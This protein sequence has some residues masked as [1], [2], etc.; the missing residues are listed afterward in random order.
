[1]A[2]NTVLDRIVVAKLVEV[3]KIKS[4]KPAGFGVRS[5]AAVPAFRGRDFLGALRSVPPGRRAVIAEL[6]RASP[7]AGI[8]RD[9]FEPAVLARAFESNGAAAL[10]A[11]T[12]VEFF[13]GSLAVLAEARA[14]T[15]LPVLRKDF[16]IDA[17]QVEEAVAAGADAVLLIARILDDELFQGLYDE[18]RSQ[19][20]AVLVEV[21][22]QRDLERSLAL[23]PAP[24]L[25]GI[26]NRNLSDFTVS[27][28]RTL[29]LL[30]LIP[31][32]ITVVSES[33]LSDPATLDLLEKAGVHAFLIGTAL[34]RAPDPGQALRNLVRKE[35]GVMVHL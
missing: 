28:E 7:S 10:S 22:D 31:T 19:G 9:P 4:M 14:A 18:A 29:A 26:N 2:T 16:V 6:K 17:V 1:V 30:P 15:G 11:L 23:K 12:D 8:I 3:E 21:H 24:A 33:G 5:G 20:L 25:L 34:M 32:G 35:G 13:R 27:V